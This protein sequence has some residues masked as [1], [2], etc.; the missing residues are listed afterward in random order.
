MSLKKSG[1]Q[2]TKQQKDHHADQLNPN[3][4]K[5]KQ[6]QENTEKQIKQNPEKK[7]N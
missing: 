6:A 4:E 2:Y 5:F 3:N 7:N 1:D